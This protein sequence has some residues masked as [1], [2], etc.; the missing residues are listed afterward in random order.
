MF[1]LCVNVQPVY[2]ADFII[3][4]EIDGTVHQVSLLTCIG[5]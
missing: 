5:Y 4:V 2:N 3:P 1:L